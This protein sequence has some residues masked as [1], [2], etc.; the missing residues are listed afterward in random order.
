MTRELEPDNAGARIFNSLRLST[1]KFSREE[2]E[3]G[4]GKTFSPFAIFAAFAR[5]KKL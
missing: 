2:R 4:E 3:G 5:H 1:N